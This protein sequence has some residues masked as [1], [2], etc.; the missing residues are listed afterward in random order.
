MKPQACVFRAEKSPKKCS[1]FLN[2]KIKKL[3]I[4]GKFSNYTRKDMMVHPRR[5][6][7]LGRHYLQ[8]LRKSN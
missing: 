3:T 7:S 8:G 2:L 6:D 4:L 5:F 1:R